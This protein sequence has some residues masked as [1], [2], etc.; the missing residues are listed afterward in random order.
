MKLCEVD[1]SKI[2]PMMLQYIDIKEKN[3]DVILFFR[4]G[5][6]YEMFFEDAYVA[7]KELELT[8]TGKN[9]GLD[10]RIPMCGI[11]YHAA[12]IYLE[13][14]VEKGYKVAICEQ[15]EDPKTAKG[16]V[17]REVMQIVSS[18]TVMDSDALD[19]KSNNY[20]GNVLDLNS[21]YVICYTDLSTGEVNAKMI[22]HDM[23]TLINTILSLSL[24]EIV[25]KSDF[26][27]YV[28]DTL[29]NKCRLNVSISDYICNTD[30]YKYIYDNV[31]D[32]R[33][34][35]C[36][37]HLLSYL[38][39]TQKRSL[40]HLQKV[41]IIENIYLN[42]DANSI[43]NLEL[44]ESLRLKS[45]NYSLLWLLD[46]TK[47]AM[48]SR[49]LKNWI[50]NPLTNIEE[51]NKRY[52]IISTLETEFILKEELKN[53]LNEVYDL[54]R[55]CG[56]ISYG[57]TNARD[58][59]QLKNSLKVLPDINKILTDLKFYKNIE[60]LD[61]L[62]SLLDKSIDDDAPITIKEGG[63]IKRG[64]NL[65]LDSL[66]DNSKS[67]KDFVVNMESEERER[68]GIKNLKVGY[69]K[70]FGYYIEV[71]KGNIPLI[72]DE[73]NYERKQTL[74][75]CERYVTPLLKEKEAM[76]LG[77]EEKI[78]NLEYNLFIEI[79]D[80]VKN[81]ISRIQ[82]IAK[83]IAEID[84]LQSL[85]C[86]AEENNYVRPI[87]SDKRI[88]DIKGSR[89]PVVEKVLNTEYV[90][91]DIYMDEKTNILMITGPNM[92][93]KSTYERELVITS[94][95]AQM[96][97]F[98]PAKSCIIPIF[99]KVF[100]R[101][102]A[103]DDLVSGDSTFMVEMKEANIALLN[104]TKNSLIIFDELGRG[105]ATYDGLSIAQSIIEY[106]HDNI[107][108]KTL[109][110]THYHELTKLDKHFSGIKNVHVAIKEENGN[111]TFMHKVKD[112]P[113][114]KSY[115]IHV[116]KLANLPSKV[117]NRANEI[118]NTYENKKEVVF[119]EQLSI[120]IETIEKD[121]IIEDKIKN[122]DILNI[123][124]LE[125]LNFIYE[126][127]KEIDKKNN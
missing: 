43:R 109:F 28:V 95:M 65:E 8:L 84:V 25:F 33:Y 50:L 97:S 45:R 14:L 49:M 11:P 93:G 99:D 90:D 125:A 32:E 68:T 83:T 77:A 38:I 26:N 27:K 110:S 15:V 113:V 12:S 96:G 124:P 55:L 52:D 58:L 92:A 46:K 64:Y 22:N 13:K 56:R 115:G 74:A 29:R 101:I 98:V 87:I 36:I 71:S 120:P 127:K 126:L 70:I 86:V 2:S 119:S 6:F 44:V 39:D 30:E 23:D 66:K 37:N 91:N 111:I 72:K 59:I 35:I 103:S 80:I 89:H 88:I 3:M 24:N 69:N 76:I 40:T 54:E 34:I 41:N 108:C 20:I 118:L 47:T 106:I 73:Y 51:I 116:A 48:G 5:D 62:Y 16:V 18:G 60:T 122:I 123:T 105:T 100:T 112:G 1:K 61:D 17:K 21:S 114:D 79:R 67:G 117:I 82:V 10:E 81:Y 57:N 7:S 9:A 75:N 4:L 94:I 63:I 107:G 102:G 121:N 85:A 78:I 19:E 104:A 31:L 42:I 53:Y